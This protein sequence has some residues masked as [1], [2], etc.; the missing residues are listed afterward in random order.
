MT[1]RLRS[2]LQ[3]ILPLTRCSMV[4]PRRALWE[5]PRPPNRRQNRFPEEFSAIP[6]TEVEWGERQV[7]QEN[8]V[9]AAF[10]LNAKPPGE[11]G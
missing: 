11:F 6:W 3:R 7:D 2:A 1:T 8:P 9:P 10:S 4:V 5:I